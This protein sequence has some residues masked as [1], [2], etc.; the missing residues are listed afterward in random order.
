[1]LVPVLEGNG[2]YLVAV[3]SEGGVTQWRTFLGD[4]PN[5]GSAQNGAIII[6]VDGGEAYVATGV[7]LL[8]SV[9]AISGSVN[10]AVSYPRTTEKNP[11]RER[12]LQRFG[13]W[14]GRGMGGAKFDGWQEEMI[15]PSGN[16]VIVTPTDFNHLIAFDRRSGSLIWESARNPGGGEHQGEYALGVERGRVYVAGSG[17]VR[18]YKVGGGRLLW[19]SVF[20]AGYGRGA[21]T[22][23]GVF[24]PSGKNKIIRLSLETGEKSAGVEVKAFDNEPIGNLYSDG[25]R[26]YG[27]GLRK[28]YAIGEFV[29][30][31]IEVE[32]VTKEKSLGE[33]AVGANELIAET[34]LRIT[35]A[36]QRGVVD[37][38]GIA[39]GFK[40]LAKELEAIPVPSPALRSEILA[41]RALWNSGQQAQLERAKIKFPSLA[42]DASKKDSVVRAIEAFKAELMPMREI[43][44]K[45]GIEI[46]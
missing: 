22:G 30:G 9:D 6:S 43:Y 20:E 28:V 42:L 17:V 25:S 31:D 34:F 5:S 16:A 19:E 11:A 33:L 24:V 38:S 45:Y 44:S 10:W 21:L 14:G 1:V 3:E 26:L 12:Q 29:A 46:P 2:M 27:A 41:E 23:K 4:D 36:Y 15:I 32:R 8:F 7:G 40:S 37:F 13:V 35:G 18:C 39:E